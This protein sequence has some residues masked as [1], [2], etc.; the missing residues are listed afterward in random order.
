MIGKNHEDYFRYRNLP[1]ELAKPRN[2]RFAVVLDTKKSYEWEEKIV[3]REGVTSY[4]YRCLHPLLDANGAVDMVIVFGAN[5]TARVL[6]GQELKKSRDTFANAFNFSGTGMALLSV[7][8]KW[9]EVNNALCEITGYS[10]EELLNV[11]YRDITFPGDLAAD[12]IAINRLLTKRDQYVTLETRY[13]SKSK[14][15][16][17]VLL[18]VSLVWN[19]DGTPGFFIAQI[20]DITQRKELE[21]E[22]KRKNTELEA[23]RMSLVN[24]VGQMNELNHMIAHNLRGPAGNI[25]MLS[26]ADEHS[27]DALDRSE[28]MNLI[29]QSSVALIDSLNTLMETAEIKL[30]KDIAYDDCDFNEVIHNIINQLHATVYEKH[31]QIEVSLEVVSMKYPKAYLESV[32]Y[33]LLSNALKYTVPDRAPEIIVSTKKEDGHTVLRVKDNGIGIDLKRFE[34]KLFHL[35]QI[36]HSGYDSKGIGLFIT[37]TQVESLGGTISVKSEPDKGAEFIVVF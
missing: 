35:N 15:I 5:I 4:H 36:F 18:N 34:H 25:K 13:V 26:D 10:R 28:V 22:L 23:A 37:K 12:D 30:N 8:G 19:E 3:N 6:A 14:K 2:E 7:E 16:I 27:F 31:A 9:I 17:W 21:S 29:Y 20:A 33:N 11:N 32:L 24:K 1:L